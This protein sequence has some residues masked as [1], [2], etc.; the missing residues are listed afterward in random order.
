[1]SLPEYLWFRRLNIARQLFMVAAG[2]CLMTFYWCKA[3][4]AR[5]QAWLTRYF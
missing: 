2:A 1:M 3:K 5:G 4:Y